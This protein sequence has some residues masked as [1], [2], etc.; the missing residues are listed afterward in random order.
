MRRGSPP[1]HHLMTMPGNTTPGSVT[2]ADVIVVG[3]GAAGLTAARVLG[4]AGLRV[5]VLEARDRAGGRIHTLH[6]P[7]SPVPIEL[8]AEFVQGRPPEILEIVRA[9]GLPLA[10][11]LGVAWQFRKGKLGPRP[12]RRRLMGEICARLREA[13]ASGG[14]DRS[15]QEFLDAEFPGARD[16]EA[17]RLATAYVE[18]YHA[19]RG[20]RIS[21]QAL[22]AGE[23]ADDAI[24]GDRSFRIQTGD[25]A[26]TGPSDRRHAVFRWRGNRIQRPLFDRPRRHRHRVPGGKGS[27]RKFLNPVTQCKVE[28]VVR[29]RDFQ[30]FSE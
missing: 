14:P 30:V 7:A 20:E 21:I 3:A 5:V 25:A 18:R 12:S 28:P 19:A 2:D 29:Q 15:F 13:V 26:R 11:M 1:D 17:K 8:G 24:E 16:A 6:E 23:E 9:A 22:A 10:E 4:E 27:A